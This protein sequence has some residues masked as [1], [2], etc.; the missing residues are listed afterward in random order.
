MFAFSRLFRKLYFTSL[1][2]APPRISILATSKVWNKFMADTCFV[3]VKNM[4][5]TTGSSLGL[6]HIWFPS[7]LLS[8]TS[9]VIKLSRHMH[10][11]RSESNSKS[12][13]DSCDWLPIE[14][15]VQE[16]RCVNQPRIREIISLG[17]DISFWFLPRKSKH[18][19]H[20]LPILIQF[21]LC[22]ERILF[23]WWHD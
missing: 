4:S 21:L 5:G 20:Q 19:L 7:Q 9:K 2:S 16:T 8:R 18:S 3:D 15:T 1:A 22:R 17:S 13:N 11:L 23:G 6:F 12:D 14:T 10:L